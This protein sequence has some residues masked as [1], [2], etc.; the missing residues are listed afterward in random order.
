M[1]WSDRLRGLTCWYVPRNLIKD[2]FSNHEATMH[3]LRLTV[4]LAVVMPF[5]SPGRADQLA[6]GDASAQTVSLF[7]G[8]DHEGWYADVP[9]CGT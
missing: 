7:N 3:I 2:T 1:G 8:K 9:A 5:A 4:L 6:T